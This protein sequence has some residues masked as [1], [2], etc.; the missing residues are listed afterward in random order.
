MTIGG[1]ALEQAQLAYS[2]D[3]VNRSKTITRNTMRNENFSGSYL[4]VGKAGSCSPAP[5]AK[6]T[7][8]TA[9]LTPIMLCS[10]VVF[11]WQGTFSITHTAGHLVATTRI[12]TATG[13]TDCTY[14]GDYAQFGHYGRS[15]G[16]YACGDGSHGH[17]SFEQMSLQAVSGSVIFNGLLNTRDA[18]DNS[19]CS[20]FSSITGVR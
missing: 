16:T 2:I 17:S 14:T 20:D 10:C 6:P 12:P 15:Q 3:G 8:P 13:S 1:I 9:D 19:G 5:L 18:T 4:G 11:P 7:S